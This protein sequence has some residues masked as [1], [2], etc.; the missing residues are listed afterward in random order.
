MTHYRKRMGIEGPSKRRLKARN[1]SQRSALSVYEDALV[2]S[3]K[4]EKAKGQIQEASI[5]NQGP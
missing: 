4:V 5:S 1:G 2:S 3:R